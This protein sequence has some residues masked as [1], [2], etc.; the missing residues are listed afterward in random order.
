M[1]HASVAVELSV[2]SAVFVDTPVTS[3]GIASLD[4]GV[5]ST[6]VCQEEVYFGF[7]TQNARM[8][9]D[10]VECTCD[11]QYVPIVC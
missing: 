10:M 9:V 11:M 3:E 6:L 5:S 4:R 7:S 2:T 1:H 8:S